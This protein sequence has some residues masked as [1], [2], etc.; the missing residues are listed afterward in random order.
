MRAM[1]PHD[2]VVRLQYFA[3]EPDS[4]TEE[5]RLLTLFM[6]YLPSNL[7]AV[8]QDHAFGMSTSLIQIYGRQMLCGLSYLASQNI[9]HRDLLPRN[10][11]ID[12]SQQLLKLADFG[13]AK[14][15]RPEVPNHP[16][17][18]TWQYR[19][20]EL[21]FGATHYTCKAGTILCLRRL[22]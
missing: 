21:L 20:I 7:Q 14:V 17:V 15:V 22:F 9:V 11:L 3:V 19:A 10:I 1:T 16:A 6:D 12:P 4:T 8:I 18:G 5:A 2:N 13:C